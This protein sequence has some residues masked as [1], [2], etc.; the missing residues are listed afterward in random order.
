MTTSAYHKSPSNGRRLG[1]ARVST[2]EQNLGLQVDA[3]AAAG[4]ETIFEEKASGRR[5]DRPVLAEVLAALQSGDVLVVWK[6]DRVARSTRHLLEIIEALQSRGIGFVATTQSIDTTTPHGRF[7]V[8]MLAAVA[9][10]E[11]DVT[12]ERVVA[13]IASARRRGVKFGPPTKATTSR[14]EAARQLLAQDGA[15]IG[16]VARTLGMGRSTLYR[17]LRTAA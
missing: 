13:G 7:F 9:E 17:A 11:A 4:A 6:I 2:E 10:L 1:Y 15:S 5:R 14:I 12:R 8:T 3:L 16:A